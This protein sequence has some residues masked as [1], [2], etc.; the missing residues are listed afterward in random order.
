M[1]AGH[2]GL[3]KLACGKLF[4]ALWTRVRFLRLRQVPGFVFGQGWCS[5]ALETARFAQKG[6]LGVVHHQLVPLKLLKRR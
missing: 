2:M 6:T 3:Q 4:A 1:D 5:F